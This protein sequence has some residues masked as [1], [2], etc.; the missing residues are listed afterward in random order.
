MDGVSRVNVM[1][2]SYTAGPNR[3]YTP[4]VPSR[5]NVFCEDCHK[6]VRKSYFNIEIEEQYVLKTWY[7][8][9]PWIDN[10]ILEYIIKLKIVCVLLYYLR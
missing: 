5:L 7:K 4:D 6:I 3:Y 9:C 10:F 8:I 1:C 2:I